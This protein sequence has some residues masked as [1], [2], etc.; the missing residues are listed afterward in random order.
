MHVH[1]FK[2]T[3][4]ASCQKD[5]QLWSAPPFALVFSY[6]K[7]KMSALPLAKNDL[8][9]YIHAAIKQKSYGDIAQLVERQVRNL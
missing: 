7:A 9:S 8:F 6:S 4:Q 1:P 5:L 3:S 2:T